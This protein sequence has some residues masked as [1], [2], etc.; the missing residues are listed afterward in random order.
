MARPI[1]QLVTPT[2]PV[3]PNGQIRIVLFIKL[4]L[5][6]KNDG[7]HFQSKF[8][9][10]KSVR[11]KQKANISGQQRT[12]GDVSVFQTK[13]VSFLCTGL[14]RMATYVSDN[15]VPEAERQKCAAHF[16]ARCLR[17]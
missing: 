5:P 14:A 12:R 9:T 2:I 13:R 16:S 8:Y 15:F 17:T 4:A 7:Y 6:R 3:N 1:T 10:S 11:F